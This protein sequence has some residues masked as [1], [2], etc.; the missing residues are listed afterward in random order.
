MVIPVSEGFARLPV[1]FIVSTAFFRSLCFS[2]RLYDFKTS[3]K[4]SEF[5]FLCGIFEA[6]IEGTF[7]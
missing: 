1:R 5:I 7:T 6:R 4:N 3:K 2:S